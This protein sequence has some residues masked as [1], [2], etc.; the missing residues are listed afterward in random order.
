MAKS[1][2]TGKVMEVNKCMVLLPATQLGKATRASFQSLAK[3]LKRISLFDVVE[4][5]VVDQLADMQRITLLIREGQASDNESIENHFI[6]GMKVEVAIQQLNEI[7]K[8][9]SAHSEDKII[10]TMEEGA[11]SLKA[12]KVK[13]KDTPVKT[14][15]GERLLLIDGSNILATAYF[16]TRKSM[17]KNENGLY[18]NAVYVMAR[19]V[20]E[21]I[22]RSNPSHVVIAWDEGRN[23]FRKAM[24]ND[25]K[26]HRKET[27]PE[28]KEQFTTAQQLFSDLQIAQYSHM[29]IEAD[30]VIGTIN[31]IWQKEE[32]GSSVIVSNDKD[33]FQLV[34]DK[35]TQLIS[36][37]GQEYSIRPEHMKKMWN[38]T[39]GQWVDCKALLGDT[40]DNIPGVSGVGEKSV[41]PLISTYG[42][43]ENLYERLEELEDTEYKRYVKKLEKGKDEAFLSKKLATIKCDATDVIT[44]C[45]KEMQLNITRNQLI[46]YFE[47]LGFNSL[48][49]SINKGL[50]RVG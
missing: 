16:A 20:L 22:S 31:S 46:K 5:I 23:T 39:P 42:N 48:I 25:Y 6:S 40:S 24:Y 28:L 32:R 7:D 30:D 17:M 38:V 27:E 47:Q 4:E 9:I 11:I 10:V 49:Q 2:Y 1:S 13:Q 36:K 18:T 21:L 29:E 12:E 26:A 35:T 44:P 50:Y 8:Y 19:R 41:Y 15:K 45:F 3:Q 33:L 34:S 14:V 43:I 37:N